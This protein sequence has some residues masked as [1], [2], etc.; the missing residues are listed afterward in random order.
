MFSC[1]KLSQRNLVMF[2]VVQHVELEL[3]TRI[4]EGRMYEVSMEWMNC[5][6]SRKLSEYCLQLFCE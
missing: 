6:Q 5:I 1:G 3:V 2:L 4:L